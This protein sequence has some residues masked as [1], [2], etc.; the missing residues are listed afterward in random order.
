MEPSN[1]QTNPFATLHKQQ[2][3]SIIIAGVALISLFLPWITF[4]IAY[5][6]R[7]VNGLHG[8]GILSLF[9]VIGVAIASFMGDKTTVYDDTFKKVALGS[10]AAIAL[11]ALLYF[12]RLNSY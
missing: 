11:G 4:S 2:L 3:Y 1:P 5:G 9:G 10:F 7:P 6:S 12:F 8:W